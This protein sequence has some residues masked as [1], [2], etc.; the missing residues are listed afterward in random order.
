MKSIENKKFEKI[1]AFHSSPAMLGIKP[2]SLFTVADTEEAAENIRIFNGRASVKGLKI[3]ELCLIKN[4]RLLLVY[5]EKALER[6]MSNENVLKMFSKFGYDKDLSM[7]QRIDILAEKIG[8]DKVF[9]HEIGLF[10][11]YPVDDIQGFIDNKGENYLL[12]GYWKVYSDEER[13]KRI[14]KSYNNCRSYI[15]NKLNSGEDIYKA[16]RIS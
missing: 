13:A 15:I 1:L 3:R 11:G 10:L 8:A 5:N 2:A 7:E 14:F 6:Q 16:L 9:P 4:R 12:C